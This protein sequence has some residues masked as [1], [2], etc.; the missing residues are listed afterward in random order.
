MECDAVKVGHDL[1]DGGGWCTGWLLAS[2]TT[3]GVL[4]S[5][6]PAEAFLQQRLDEDIL[7]VEEK[8]GVELA[9]RTGGGWSSGRMGRESCELDTGGGRRCPLPRCDVGRWPCG[10]VA[11]ARCCCG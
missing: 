5:G 9:V 8:H 2:Y 3:G 4:G 10:W 1:V 6:A 11:A 7:V